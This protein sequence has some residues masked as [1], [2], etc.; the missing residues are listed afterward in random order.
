M[1]VDLGRPFTE[2]DI[3]END[4]LYCNTQEVK[5]HVCVIE[6]IVLTQRKFS[7]VLYFAV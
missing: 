3:F 7:V 2:D 4:K 1:N 5:D 6:F